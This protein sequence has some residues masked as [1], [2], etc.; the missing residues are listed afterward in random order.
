MGKT[1]KRGLVIE[2]GG[3]RGAHTA[4]MLMALTRQANLPSFDVV[5]ATSAGA[6]SGAFF[7]AHQC[8]QLK[9]V[10]EE[11]FRDKQFI[12]L[13]RTF[14]RHSVMDFDYLVDEVFRKK[15][16]LDYQA[17]EK[18]PCD[19]FIC[20][21]NCETGAPHYF[22]NRRDP[23]AQA[24]KASGAI[25]LAYKAPI[26]IE[27]TRYVDGGI[28]DSVPVKKAMAEGC[29][30]IWVLLTQTE[31]YRK[32][33]SPYFPWRFTSFRHYSK[34]IE[35]I[36]NRHIHYN[37]TLDFL[38][39]PPDSVRIHIFRPLSPLTLN[40]FT[41]NLAKIR[42]TMDQGQSDAIVCLTKVSYL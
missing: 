25:P 21:T 27:G 9:T 4:G 17:I 22:R 29:D 11:S 30:E 1:P 38:H 5:C 36:K 19:F 41:S 12:D 40:R 20:A 16:P 32:K 8:D 6:S 10:W 2:G 42:K 34:L 15:I 23:L 13:K 39:S 26:V 31:D 3:S 14:S 18:N 35:A 24:L 28:S 37:A 33:P 7:V